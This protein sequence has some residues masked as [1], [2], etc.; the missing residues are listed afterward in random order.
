MKLSRQGYDIR[1][2]KG[3]VAHHTLIELKSMNVMAPIL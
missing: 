2:I 1:P 3:N